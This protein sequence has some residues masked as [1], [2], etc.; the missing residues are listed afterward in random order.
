MR[1]RILYSSQNLR[2]IDHEVLKLHSFMSDM[3]GDLSQV[4]LTDSNG[5]RLEISVSSRLSSGVQISGSNVNQVL[6]SLLSASRAV[7]D[8]IDEVHSGIVKTIEIFDATESDN[9]NALNNG[10]AWK[11]EQNVL[12]ASPIWADRK[13]SPYKPIS[14]REFFEEQA[15]IEARNRENAAKRREEIKQ[16]YLEI[17]R[18]ADGDP[19]DNPRL[20]ELMRE[21]LEMVGFSKEQAEAVVARIGSAP[22]DFR[23]M[24]IYSFYDYDI[25]NGA[26][27]GYDGIYKSKENK[28]YVNA[29][30]FASEE[31]LIEIFFHEAGHAVDAN[32]HYASHDKRL[33]KAIVSDTEKYITG[34]LN[35]QGW[36]LTDAE[37]KHV[38]KAFMSGKSPESEVRVIKGGYEIISNPPN[39]L[40]Q[41]ERNVYHEI[42]ESCFYEFRA[43]PIGNDV[44]ASDVMTGV[45]N[46]AMTSAAGHPRAYTGF[47]KTGESYWY[48]WYGT[49]KDNVT[50]EAWAEH[51]SSQFTGDQSAIESNAS[52]MGDSVKRMNEIAVNVSIEYKNIHAL[53]SLH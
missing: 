45:T 16:S 32:A 53:K 4:E 13:P 19:F 25:V 17:L 52:L 2:D 38:L 40:S 35:K 49:M 22:D 1:D 20:A 21:R 47:E 34:H 9:I 11:F 27:S 5:G 50:K 37:K 10:T 14:A 12:L 18:T 43:G 7:C 44:I 48:T 15:E 31:Q 26:S 41:R 23:N 36:Y 39:N 42:V 29:A 28:M 33:R 6:Q 8:E 46:N 3:I 51:F 24:Y 30:A